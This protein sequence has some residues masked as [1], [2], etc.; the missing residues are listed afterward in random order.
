MRSSLREHVRLMR[1]R[2]WAKNLLV[3]VPA[4][5][6]DAFREEGVLLSC[7]VGF[8]L[9]SLCASATYVFND[10][11]D[12]EL[13]RRHAAKKKRPLASKAVSARSA[14]IMGLL[15]VAFALACAF[16]W[17][18]SLAA[19]LATYCLCSILYTVAVKKILLFDTFWLS[20][21]HTARLVIGGIL[22]DVVLSGWLIAFSLVFFFSLTLAK[23]Y[24]E[25]VLSS[26]DGEGGIHGRAYTMR[27]ATLLQSFGAASAVG[28]IVV[29]A[30]YVTDRDY[31]GRYYTHPDYLWLPVLIIAAWL[32]HIWRKA[33]DGSLTSDPVSF[34]LRDRT[35]LA[36]FMAL[37]ATMWL[38][39]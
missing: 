14:G 29:L 20:G 4:F 26:R 38:A 10:L 31:S 37:V 27:D 17:Q 36:L 22:A 35:S 8:A 19:V 30:L 39:K 7:T 34:A 13:D 5:L 32:L 21:M 15:L 2:Y 33:H 6:A 28:S 12:V 9:L 24:C 1:P 11:A 18:P 16:A 3:F 23:R 25:L